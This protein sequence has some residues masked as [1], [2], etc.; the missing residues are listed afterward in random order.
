MNDVN[1]ATDKRTREKA[2]PFIASPYSNSSIG[3]F[4]TTDAGLLRSSDLIVAVRCS[5]PDRGAITEAHL[6]M[7][8]QVHSA[9]NVYVGVGKFDSDGIAAYQS[10]SSSEIQAMHQRLMGSSSPIASSAGTLFIDGLNILPLIPKRGHANF[11]Q[12]GF[13]LLF[14]FSRA[15]I[16]ANDV[17]KSFEAVCSAQMGLL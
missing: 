17:L 4:G 12:D 7:N 16:S 6:N 8:M 13:V 10:Y 11:N 3:G 15:R 14:L 5:T 9:T 2:V 1:A